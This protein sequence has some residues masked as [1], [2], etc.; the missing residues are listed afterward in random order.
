MYSQ[1][2]DDSDQLSRDTQLF[3]AIRKKSRKGNKFI[4]EKARLREIKECLLDGANINAVDENDIRKNT[5]LHIAVRKGYK[6]IVE[7][8]VNNQADVD[9]RNSENET[10]LDIARKQNNTEIISILEGH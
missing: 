9:I 1:S 4:S 10:P 3:S 7:F 6:E 8:F 2:G 5:V